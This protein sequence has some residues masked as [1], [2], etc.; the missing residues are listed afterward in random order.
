M[1]YREY[2]DKN[3]RL[4]EPMSYIWLDGQLEQVLPCG[5]DELG[6]CADNK[7]F[8]RLHPTTNIMPSCYP[9]WQFD[10]NDYE[11]VRLFYV[12]VIEQ[13]NDSC[14]EDVF[15][16]Q[17]YYYSREQALAQKDFLLHVS[18]NW[19]IKTQNTYQFC[20]RVYAEQKLSMNDILN[21]IEPDYWIADVEEIE[22]V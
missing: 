22:N 12:P 18:K 7:E 5:D 16:E 10:H 11:S 8:F 20:L 19:R 3:G 21:G 1:S 9:L 13:V 17:G 4:V 15:E 14:C 6:I 2:Y